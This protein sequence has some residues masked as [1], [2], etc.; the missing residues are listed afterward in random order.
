MFLVSKMDGFGKIIGFEE[1]KEV[2]CVWI[3]NY[4]VNRERRCDG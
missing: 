4:I 3:E 1:M 2:K